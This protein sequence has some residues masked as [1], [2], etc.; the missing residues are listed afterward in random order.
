MSSLGGWFERL[1]I[2][3]HILVGIGLLIY[4]VLLG[5]RTLYGVEVPA[6]VVDRIK[7]RDS[8]G[9]KH[10]KLEIEY[11]YQ[12][13]GYFEDIGLNRKQYRNY[14]VG[15]KIYVHFLPLARSYTQEVRAQGTTYEAPEIQ[16]IAFYLF[17]A[18]FWNCI[19][20]LFFFI[21]YIAPVIE[22][23]LLR[24][25]RVS[26]GLVKGKR[27][28]NSGDNTRYEIEYVFTP[29]KRASSVSSYLTD[30]NSVKFQTSTRHSRKGL[31]VVSKHSYDRINNGDKLSVLYLP[32]FPKIN[33]TLELSEYEL[34]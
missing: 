12:G 17:F 14:K 19:V 26:T 21:M 15:E 34:A 5:A 7:Y 32:T 23:W 33:M 31:A 18:S 8:D 13:K 27:I 4:P 3:P 30:H 22:W 16:T 9:D 24:Y 10:Y 6:T 1:F 11:D 25:G 28:D 2:L 29:G 20:G